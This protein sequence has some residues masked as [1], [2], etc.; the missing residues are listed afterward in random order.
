MIT[1]DSIGKT[2]EYFTASAWSDAVNSY[3]NPSDGNAVLEGQSFGFKTE[4]NPDGAGGQ[5]IFWGNYRVD[6]DGTHTITAQ[7]CTYYMEEIYGGCGGYGGWINVDFGT[8]SCEVLIQGC[9][10]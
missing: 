8:V 6:R 9:V 10:D 2:C 3:C 4:N 5:Q 7:E 1:D